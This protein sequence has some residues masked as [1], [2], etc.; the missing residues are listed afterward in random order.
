MAQN[1][2]LDIGYV[3]YKEPEDHQWKE[4]VL[5]VASIRVERNFQ[6]RSDP[7]NSRV[8]RTY[9]DSMEDGAT[10]PPILVAKVDKGLYVVDGF[11]R[12]AATVAAGIKTIRAKVA[13]M[14]A[15]E[16]ALVALRANT[17]HGLK[18]STKDKR[19]TLEQYVAEGFHLKHSGRLKPSRQIAR[20]LSN[21]MHYS[22]IHK[23]LTKELGLKHDDDE[24]NASSSDYQWSYWG[25][26]GPD[27]EEGNMLEDATSHIFHIRTLCDQLSEKTSLQTVRREL[28]ALI[29]M[30]DLELSGEEHPHP[31]P[32][33][34]LLDI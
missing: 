26:E 17:T 21:V 1:S 24:E 13:P 32:P 27:Q 5:S 28:A 34:Q 9:A 20:E 33:K 16:A 22:T 4:R 14:T 7:Y 30:V 6:P 8:V 23:Y 18:L 10:F 2:H 11:H 12:L 19:R 29:E 3:P 15:T 25:A 31:T